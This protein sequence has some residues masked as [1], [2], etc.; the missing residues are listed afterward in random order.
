M[1]AV[2]Q[3]GTVYSVE[4]VCQSPIR[5][6]NAQGDI[7]LVLRSEDGN[8]LISGTSL[9]GAMRQWI[10]Q[11]QGEHV[12][13]EL[14][15][16]QKKAGILIVSDGVF[17]ADAQQGIRPRLRMN[18]K[19][20]T[21]EH[22]GK[23]DVAQINTG[24]R[25][26]FQLI[27]LEQERSEERQQQ[28]KQML[29]AIHCGLIRLGAQKT[30]GFGR[31]TLKVWCRE[32]DMTKEQDRMAWLEQ[33]DQG[34]ECPLP[35]PSST[36][37]VTFVVHAQTDHILVKA[38]ATEEKDGQQCTVPLSEGGNALLPASS[39][40]GAIRSQVEKILNSTGRSLK[41][42][43]TLF[44]RGNEE[45]DNGRAGQVIC[46]DVRLEGKKQKINRIR[47]NRFTG[48][49]MRGGL[50]CEEPISSPIQFQITAPAD[51]PQGCAALVYALRDLAYGF[52]TLGSGAAVGR[53][54]LQVSSIEIY[55]DEG[56][57]A[58]L[59]FEKGTGT[60]ND[61]QHLVAGWLKAWK[62]GATQ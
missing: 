50:F 12:A 49:V 34:T 8:A 48:G 37:R 2:F 6:G 51:Q 5:T 27:S 23:F 31:M 42:S 20:G 10:S 1:K 52:Y 46:Q 40:K 9:A 58:Q 24:S 11:Q 53:G 14:F 13:E 33:T 62:E 35:Q 15:G 18:R 56:Q 17:D 25:C 55:T 16:S 30:N 36:G 22:G 4:G 39:I 54:F 57:K 61:T 21:A 29:G 44:G 43:E 28:V 41:L 45:G 59:Q 47:M 60:L 19:T 32:Y 3:Y 26:T 38:G 7:E